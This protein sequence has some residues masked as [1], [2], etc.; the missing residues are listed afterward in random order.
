MMLQFSKVYNKT[1]VT[2]RRDWE[3]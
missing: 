1:R 3:R 2:N